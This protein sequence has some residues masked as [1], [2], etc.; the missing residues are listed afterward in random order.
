[1]GF[2]S[3]LEWA[4]PGARALRKRFAS[5][6]ELEVLARHGDERDHEDLEDQVA[7]YPDFAR[8]SAF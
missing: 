3:H 5:G 6:L 2:F 8:A 4:N 7:T 1:V